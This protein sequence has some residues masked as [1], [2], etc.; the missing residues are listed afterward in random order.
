MRSHHDPLET[1]G[2]KLALIWTGLSLGVA[3]LATPAKFLAPSLSLP[4]ALDVGRHTFRVCNRVELA[5]CVMLIVLA[6]WAA[7]RDR[8]MLAFALPVALVLLQT[9][10][11]IPSLD[12][13]V[14]LVLQGQNPPPSSLHLVYVVIEACKTLWLASLGFLGWP[15]RSSNQLGD[16]AIRG[17]KVVSLHGFR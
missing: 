3:F 1:F 15:W 8:W 9:A 5:L 10:W 7:R 2:G 12:A 17:A 16:L 13:R 6:V 14:G 11:L 4:A